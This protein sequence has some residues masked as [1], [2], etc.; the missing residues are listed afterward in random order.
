MSGVNGK[1]CAELQ[2]VRQRGWVFAVIIDLKGQKLGGGCGGEGGRGESSV[3]N[4]LGSQSCMRVEP[5][6]EQSG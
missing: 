3:G 5:S 6:S 4:A 1:L 2:E